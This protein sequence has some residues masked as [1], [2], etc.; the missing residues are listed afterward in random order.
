MILKILFTLTFTLPYVY[1]VYCM[2]E[3]AVASNTVYPFL[4]F[5]SPIIILGVVVWWVAMTTIWT[6]KH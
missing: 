6:S 2:Y 3:E 1:I 4:F 5:F